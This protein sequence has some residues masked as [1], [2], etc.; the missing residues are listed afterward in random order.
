MIK[1]KVLVFIDYDM[2]IRHFILSSVFREL[3]DSYEVKYVFHIDKKRTY[4]GL[5]M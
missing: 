3:E 4:Q 5:V 2:L 1:K